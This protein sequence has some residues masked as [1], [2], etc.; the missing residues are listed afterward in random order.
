MGSVRLLHCQSLHR[1]L[2]IISIADFI[3]LPYFSGFFGG[4][5]VT[6][7]YITRLP[8]PIEICPVTRDRAATCSRLASKYQKKLCFVS[9][10]A[11]SLH[12]K[13][14]LVVRSHL[15]S[16][17]MYLLP[18]NPVLCITKQHPCLFTFWRQYCVRQSTSVTDWV[19]V[20][21]N[22]SPFKEWLKISS[23]TSLAMWH[24]AIEST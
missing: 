18:Q 8:Q 6:C 9:K 17:C 22:I 2:F 7:T 24:R 23:K 21:V 12:T 10:Q 13:L 5:Q 14:G 4:T 1:L 16:L 20:Y 3:G 15:A 19:S 11:L